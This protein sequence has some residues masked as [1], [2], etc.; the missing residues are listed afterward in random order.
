MEL[1][2]TLGLDETILFQFGIFLVV[3]LFLSNILFKPYMKAFDK[4]SEQT[5]GKTDTAERF[6]VEAQELENEYETKAREINKKFK[7][8]Y[9][10]SR[11]LA[12][13]EHDHLVAEARSSAKEITE[14]AQKEITIAMQE[15]Q[16]KLQLEVPAIA[17]TISNQVIGGG[18]V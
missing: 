12:L 11:T 9:D 5:V 10:E 16:K 7:V 14:K 17:K 8:I 1:F 2:K 4:R 3:Y 15:A 18:A 6:I 13:K